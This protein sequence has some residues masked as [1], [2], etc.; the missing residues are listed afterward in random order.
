MRPGLLAFGL[1]VAPSFGAAHPH[2]FIETTLQAVV[3]ADGTFKG[4]E[5]TW[6]YDDFYSLLLFA[7]MKLDNDADGNLR[8]DEL[9]QLEGFDLNWVDGYEGDSYAERDGA[10]V[11][12][13]AP[14]SRG[15][16][17]QGGRITSTHFRAA[18]APASGLVI[19]IYDPTFYT[20]YEIAGQVEVDGPCTASIEPANL[21]AAYSYVEELLYATPASQAQDEFPEVGDRFADTVM[22]SCQP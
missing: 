4:V 20:A 19:K 13:G 1:C 11:K 16:T 14:E 3:D 9:A 2:I 5:V 10:P 12:L 6:T 18:D 17:V 21:D 15:V 7:D 8:P 22:L